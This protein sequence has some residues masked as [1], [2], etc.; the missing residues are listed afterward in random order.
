M[1]G[2]WGQVGVASTTGLG[3]RSFGGDADLVH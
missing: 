2:G 3:G 1:W